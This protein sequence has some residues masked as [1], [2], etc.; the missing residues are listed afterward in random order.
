MA[1]SNVI[2]YVSSIETLGTVDGPGVRFVVFL[3]GCT[4]RCLYCHNPET[5]DKNAKADEFTPEKLVKQVLRYRNYFGESGGVTFSGGEPLLQPEFLLECLK[6]LKKA[7][8]H[9]CIDTAGVG[10]GNYAEILNYVDLAILDV[11]AVD[12]DEYQRLTGRD[13]SE[14]KRFLSDVQ[15]SGTKIWLRQVVVP[16]INDDEKHILKLKDFAKNLQNVERIEL[17]PYRTMGE[18]KYKNLGL[19]YPLVGVP[20]MDN[21]RLEELN[22]IIND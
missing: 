21:E 7:N 5:W 10:L 19:P 2:G 1:K 11:K 15:K 12:E 16:G 17:L 22:K 14:F 13:M 6:E 20:E 18:V 4:L 8:I 3:R 9:T